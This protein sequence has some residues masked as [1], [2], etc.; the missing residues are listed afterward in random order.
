MALVFWHHILTYESNTSHMKIKHV[1]SDSKF[2]MMSAR[3]VDELINITILKPA[4]K[5]KKQVDK[6][7][8]NNWDMPVEPRPYRRCK[9]HDPL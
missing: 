4:S 2:R 9:K 8:F 7:V 6:K 5:T 1:K 3:E